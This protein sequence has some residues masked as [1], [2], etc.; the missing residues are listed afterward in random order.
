[1]LAGYVTGGAASLP[2]AAA[3]LAAAVAARRNS[4]H[5]AAQGIIGIGVVGLFGLLFIGRFFGGLSLRTDD[6]VKL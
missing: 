5:P 3:L 6:I 1:M 4:H 2:P